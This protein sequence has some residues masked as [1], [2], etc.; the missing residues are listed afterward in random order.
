MFVMRNAAED[1]E[2]S[3]VPVWAVEEEGV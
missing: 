2:V 1:E 3:D